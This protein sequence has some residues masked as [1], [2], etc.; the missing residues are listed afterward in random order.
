[1]EIE[2]VFFMI[3]KTSLS[4]GIKSPSLIWLGDVGQNQ[5]FKSL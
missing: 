4:S 3:A 2:N 1:M 5:V